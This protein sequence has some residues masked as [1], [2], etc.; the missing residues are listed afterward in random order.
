M[1][2]GMIQKKLILNVDIKILKSFETKSR[3]ERIM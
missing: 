2:M 1:N 3:L